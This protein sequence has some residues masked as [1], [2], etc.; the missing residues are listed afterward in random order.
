MEHVTGELICLEE[1]ESCRKVEFRCADFFALGLNLSEQSDAIFFAVNV[2][3]KLFPE[4]C[5]R[6]ARAKEGCRLFTYHSL[7]TIWWIDEPC[8]FRQCEA[9]VAETDTFS[10]SWS[11]QG[12]R[13][14]VY[15]CD[16]SRE[17]QITAHSRNETFSEWQSIWDEASQSYYYHNQETESSQWDIPHHAGCWQAEWSAEHA[18]YFFWHAPTGHA[19]WEVPKCLADLGWGAAADNSSS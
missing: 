3:C 13:F 5:R 14:Y 8:P 4:L 17:P 1:I 15:V 2:P 7:E 6:F 16:R 10:T 18:A 11:P 12:Y 9:N 19:Q